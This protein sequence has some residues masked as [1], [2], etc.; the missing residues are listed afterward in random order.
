MQWRSIKVNR[1]ACICYLE[2]ATHTALTNRRAVAFA[3]VFYYVVMHLVNP[4]GGKDGLLGIWMYKYC[5]WMRKWSCQEPAKRTS[6]KEIEM[7][8]WER[9]IIKW[10]EKGSKAIR[11]A[12]L[13]ADILAKEKSTQRE[14][15]NNTGFNQDYTSTSSSRKESVTECY[16]MLPGEKLQSYYSKRRVTFKRMLLDRETQ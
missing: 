1:R 12:D 16:L 14:P 8:I 9:G 6:L 3:H 2:P 5:K 4:H 10:K 11:E 13:C 15:R 7:F